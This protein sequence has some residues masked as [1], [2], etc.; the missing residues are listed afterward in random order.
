VPRIAKIAQLVLAFSLLCGVI[1]GGAAA[2]LRPTSAAPRFAL[3]DLHGSL[4]EVK[5]LHGKRLLVLYFF[6]VESRPSLEGLGALDLLAR[7]HPG[8]LAVY[9]VSSSPPELIRRYVTEH[10]ISI[11]QLLDTNRVRDL[12]GARQVLPVGCIVGQDFRVLEYY[13]GGGAGF[14]TAIFGR[15][16]RELQDRERPAARTSTPEAKLVGTLKNTPAKEAPALGTVKKTPAKEA[17]ALGTVKKTPAK[18]APALGTVKKTPA[19]ESP[20]GQAA[21]APVGEPPASEGKVQP[22]HLGKIIDESQW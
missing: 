17:P 6:D 7:Q 16:R 3:N 9:G 12:Y 15:I 10:H 19:K 2:E 11:P 5:S 4:V 14:N 22:N 13:Q 8:E 1:P 20:S 18:E 21:Q